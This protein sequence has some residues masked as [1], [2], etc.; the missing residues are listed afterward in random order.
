MYVIMGVADKAMVWRFLFPRS[1][2]GGAM[3][4]LKE[5]TKFVKALTALIQAVKKTK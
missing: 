1:K 3:Q 4:M 2:G 5:L